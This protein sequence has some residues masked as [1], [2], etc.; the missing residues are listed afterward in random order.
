MATGRMEPT[1][2]RDLSIIMS[3]DVRFV[4]EKRTEERD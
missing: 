2:S 4:E 1:S 3:V